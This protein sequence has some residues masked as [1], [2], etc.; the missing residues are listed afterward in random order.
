MWSLPEINR[1]NSEARSRSE[2]TM[3]ENYTWELYYINTDNGPMCLPCA[4][5]EYI[6]DAGNWIE[7]SPENIA[8]LNFDRVRQAKHVIG[9]SMPVPK[10]IHEFGE[11]VVMDSSTGGQVHGA[12][13]ADPTPDNGVAALRAT[14]TQAMDAGHKRALLILDG[15]YQFAV[16]IGVYVDATVLSKTEQKARRQA[17]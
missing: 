13:Y 10:T 14:L 6:A 7:L 2:R 5:N 11:G 4:A 15:G 16:T 12:A 1:L 3:V 9:V 17:A 8:A